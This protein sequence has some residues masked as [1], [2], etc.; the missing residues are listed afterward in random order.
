MAEWMAQRRVSE[1]TMRRDE[2]K[3]VAELYAEL[4]LKKLPRELEIEDLAMALGISKAEAESLLWTARERWAIEEKRMLEPRVAATHILNIAMA[5]VVVAALLVAGGIGIG[6]AMAKHA[7]PTP[8]VV[9][10]K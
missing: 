8:S 3:A 10:A 7:A 5:T 4:K 1:S 6:N 2:A 9:K